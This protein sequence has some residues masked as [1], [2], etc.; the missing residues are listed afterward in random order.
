MSLLTK[1]ELR[2]IPSG[3]NCPRSNEILVML[4]RALKA[5]VPLE[6]FS[7]LST[8]CLSGVFCGVES[9]PPKAMNIERQRRIFV[10]PWSDSIHTTLSR[11]NKVLHSFHDF[12]K[13]NA[14]SEN[15]I[16]KVILYTIFFR[17]NTLSSS[18]TSWIFLN[19]H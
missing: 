3:K 19:L 5:E 4:N 12:S 7:I 13:S 2:M 8:K 10:E 16:R 9:E 6:V 18:K 17:M 15:L 1:D 11:N 14:F